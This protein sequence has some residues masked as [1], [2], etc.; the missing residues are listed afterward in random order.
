MGVSAQHT[1]GIYLLGENQAGARQRCVGRALYSPAA[2]GARGIEGTAGSTACS[3]EL[4]L[5]MGIYSAGPSSSFATAEQYV[6]MICRYFF[7]TC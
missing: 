3:L 4:I 6:K 7:C 5:V 2:P 1:Y